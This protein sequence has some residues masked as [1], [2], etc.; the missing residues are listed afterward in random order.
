MGVRLSVN[1][2]QIPHVI[3]G[4]AKLSDP[5]SRYGLRQE[6]AAEALRQHQR[7][8]SRREAPDGT[9]WAPRKREAP[10]PLLED[11]GRLRRSMRGVVGGRRDERIDVKAGHGMVYPAVHQHGSQK[12]NIPAR[13]F[14][15]FGESDIEQLRDTSEEWLG[16]HVAEV[17][18]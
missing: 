8:F 5:Y 13:P 18:R 15:G 6:L 1:F 4:L 3:Q 16:F 17:I 12:L 14:L 2:S 10:H 11:T 9:P 7:R